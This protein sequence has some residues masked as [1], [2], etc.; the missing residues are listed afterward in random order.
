MDEIEGPPILENQ[1]LDIYDA[2]LTFRKTEE[3]PMVTIKIRYSKRICRKVKFPIKFSEKPEDEY[4]DEGKL[5]WM[6]SYI[7]ERIAEYHRRSNNYD[8]VNMKNEKV[9]TSL[10]QKLEMLVH[11]V[12]LRNIESLP[13]EYKAE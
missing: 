11:E 1:P 13:H 3:G 7:G 10:G 5:C 8:Y 9:T 12:C 2:R 4:I 6:T